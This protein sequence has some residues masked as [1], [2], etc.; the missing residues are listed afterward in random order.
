MSRVRDVHLAARLPEA[1]GVVVF[2]G[3]FLRIRQRWF[4]EGMP[5][6]G[7]TTWVAQTTIDGTAIAPDQYRPLMPWVDHLLAAVGHVPLPTGILLSD[8]AL[9]VVVLVL[10]HHLES[11]LQAPGALLAGAAVWA[12]WVAKL[13][14][15]DPQVMLLTAVVT[16][17]ALLLVDDRAPDGPILVLGL[18]TCGART[19]Y[20]AGLGLVVVAI[21]VHH[22]RWRT[23]VIGLGLIVAA[24]VAT[25]VLKDVLYPQARYDVAVVQL[26]FNLT[27]GVW[28]MVLTF[29]GAVLITPVL[30]ALRDRSVPP[31]APVIL[32]FLIQF[33]AT[34]VVGRVEESRIF[35]PF[36]PAL[37]VAAVLA[38]R[39]L[40]DPTPTGVATGQVTAP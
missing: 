33:V 11:R 30:V 10:L 39:R 29:Y 37:G 22:R 19:D 21:G 32:W 3:C 24:V 36:A 31:M 5:G 20:A 7:F 38:Y 23:T 2:L 28:A 15:W 17:V 40:S 16:A 27:A 4:I 34:F 35:M 8:L 1:V 6:F 25:L 13:D 9:L 18:I 14:H 12:Y 26:P